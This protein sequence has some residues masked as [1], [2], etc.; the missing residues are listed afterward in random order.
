MRILLAAAVAA[1]LAAGSLSVLAQTPPAQPTTPAPAKPA[2][3]PKCRT[4]KDEAACGARTDCT[5]VAPTG[6]Q[7]AGKCKKTPPAK[8]S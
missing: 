6:T 4:L 3:P 8:K 2:G 5:W 1:S 7:A